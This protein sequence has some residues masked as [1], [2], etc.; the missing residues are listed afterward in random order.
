MSS[1]PLCSVVLSVGPFIV[2]DTFLF[3]TSRGVV[4]RGRGSC[5]KQYPLGLQPTCKIYWL[6][7]QKHTLF[8]GDSC[9]A[10]CRYKYCSYVDRYPHHHRIHQADMV[11]INNLQP[12]PSL[13]IRLGIRVGLMIVTMSM[14]NLLSCGLSPKESMPNLLIW[15]T[16]VHPRENIRKGISGP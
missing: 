2:F 4:K 6:I 5:N 10:H 16:D 15:G 14:S 7:K 8:L 11:I 9:L 1:L 3:L 13:S 12:Y